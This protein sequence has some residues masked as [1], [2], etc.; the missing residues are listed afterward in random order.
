M[1][2]D[3]FDPMPE[4]QI[5]EVVHKFLEVGYARFY[6]V[7]SFKTFVDSTSFKNAEFVKNR[8]FYFWAITK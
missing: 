1:I 8:G 5:F 4:S 3:I 6:D 7:K 2:P